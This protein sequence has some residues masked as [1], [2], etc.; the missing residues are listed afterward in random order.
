VTSGAAGY[1]DYF[2]AR[3]GPVGTGWYA[4]DLGAWRIYALN[5]NCA[6][7]G[8][9]AGS[10]QEQW[11]RADLATSPRACVLAYWHHPRFSSGEHGNDSAVTPLWNA[12]YEAD[13]DV[14]VNGHDHN[15]ERFGP[16]TPSGTADAARGIRQFV[17]GTGGGS[18]RSFETIRANS[19]VRNSDTYGVIKLTLSPTGYA[20]QFVPIAG[21]T[22]ADSGT[23]ACH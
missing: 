22:F 18:L 19:Q 17:V 8:C 13:A 23:G 5:S 6:V 3:A 7:V 10:E 4:Y 14:I 9:G 16:Q 21:K 2:G 11:L 12:L 1:F 20:W 15:Y